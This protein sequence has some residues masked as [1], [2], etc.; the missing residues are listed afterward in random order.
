M[1][2]GGMF[3]RVPVTIGLGIDYSSNFGA[4]GR[5]G[6]T[7]GMVQCLQN[8]SAKYCAESGTLFLLWQANFAARACCAKAGLYLCRPGA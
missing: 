3:C 8:Q 5:Q 7:C 1:P 4:N 6:P 2:K